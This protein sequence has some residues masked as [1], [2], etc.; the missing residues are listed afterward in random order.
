MIFYDDINAFQ[1]ALF[2]EAMA[3]GAELAL[4]RSAQDLFRFLFPPGR[5]RRF[6][7]DAGY[8]LIAGF[9]Y[10]SFLLE[11]NYGQP[12]LYLYFGS[13]IGFAVW[14]GTAGR[15]VSLVGRLI[16]R[17]RRAIRRVLAPPL[18][19]IRSFLGE[20][21]RRMAAKGET[22]L[23]KS[24]ESA[25]KLLKKERQIVY[26]PLCLGIRKYRNLFFAGRRVRT[27]S[28][29]EKKGRRGFEAENQREEEQRPVSPACGDRIRGVYPV[30]S[31]ELSGGHHQKTLGARGGKRGI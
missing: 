5:R 6:W 22:M 8:C 30:C 12:R 26:N 3:F 19:R 27:L 9:L 24:S 4:C 17:I 13:A 20:I 18:R 31:G 7:G 29:E 2:L 11:R 14:M 23:K 10:F 16:A 15:L 21:G 25:K 1:T 28:G